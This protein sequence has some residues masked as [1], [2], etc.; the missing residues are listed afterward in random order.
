LCCA[1]FAATEAWASAQDL[2]GFGSRGPALAGAATALARD[3]EA[4][5]YNPAGLALSDAMSISVGFQGA[6][7]ALEGSGSADTR[8]AASDA[9]ASTA[10]LVGAALPLPLPEPF[11][12]RLFLGIGLFVPNDA[13]LRARVPEAYAPQ[14]FVLGNRANSL[15]LQ[16]ALAARVTDWLHIG[17]GVRALARLVGSIEVSPNPQGQLGSAVRDELLVVLSPNAGIRVGPFWGTS[18]GLTYRAEQKSSFALPI[19]AALGD[20]FPLEVPELRIEGIAQFDPHQVQLGVAWEHP[21]GIAAELGALWRQWSALP[22]PIENTTS[23]V[24]PQPP[25]GASDTFSPRLGV[26]G[27]FAIREWALSAR[28]G[29]AYEPSP[30]GPQTGARNLLDA[31]RHVWSLGFGAT[32][33]AESGTP[34]VSIDAYL[35]HHVLVERTHAKTAADDSPALQTTGGHIVAFGASAQVAF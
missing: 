7:F 8:A 27:R 26:E 3:F 20:R 23:A 24:A 12:R 29:Y 9:E 10:I 6:S 1:S 4:I 18:V 28:G 32:W 13:I 11:T 5:W 35:Q 15:S 34:R 21:M 25:V 2:F 33:Q 17:L 30:F 19:R 16:A 31:N 22:R 14:F